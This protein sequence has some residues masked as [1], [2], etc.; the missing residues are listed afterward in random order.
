MDKR[1]TQMDILQNIANKRARLSRVDHNGKPVTGQRQ[2]VYD[3]HG[4]RVGIA[5]PNGG[6][7]E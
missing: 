5:Q 3:D 6:D 7:D 1:P 4:R 2:F